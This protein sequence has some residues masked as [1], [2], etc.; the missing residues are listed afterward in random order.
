MEWIIE[1]WVFILVALLCLGMHFFGHGSH[2]GH[3]GCHGKHDG[4]NG[5]GTQKPKA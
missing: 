1:N 4:D 3:G 2:S 5:H